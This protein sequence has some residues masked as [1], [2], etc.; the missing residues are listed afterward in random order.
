MRDT[1]PI[2]KKKK[3]PTSFSLSLFLPLIKASSGEEDEC[4]PPLQPLD[5][6]T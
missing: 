1:K 6:G 4:T 3:A 5:N 2:K